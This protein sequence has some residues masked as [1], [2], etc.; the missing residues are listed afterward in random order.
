MKKW[1]RWSFDDR[2]VWW[3]M[4]FCRYRGLDL[5]DGKGRSYVVAVDEVAVQDRFVMRKRWRRVESVYVIR[6]FRSVRGTLS[7]LSFEGY[8]LLYL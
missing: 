3:V 8:W 6:V 1:R 2:E 5:M 7:V 4:G